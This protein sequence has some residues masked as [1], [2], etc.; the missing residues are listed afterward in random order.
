MS[1]PPAPLAGHNQPPPIDFE[2]V[3]R[4]DLLRLQLEAQ[5]GDLFTKRDQLLAAGARFE[6]AMAELGIQDDETL[7]KAA[8]FKKQLAAFSKKVEST[9]EEVKAPFNEAGKVVQAFFKASILDQIAGVVSKVTVQQTAYLRAKEARARAE[10]EAAARLAQQEA[11]KAAA[12]AR[13]QASLAAAERAIEAEQIAA[14]AAAAAQVKPADLARTTSDLG[15]TTSLRR[16]LAFKVVDKAKV[17]LHL[18]QVV[19]AAVLQQGRM[20]KD[21]VQE[22][23][24]PGVEFHWVTAAR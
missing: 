3:L 12:A 9:R 8:D 15:V 1:E 10:R 21:P 14:D 13:A 2:E 20:A 22:Q 7:G 6:A 24:V 4:P 11:E 17:P 16:T 23:P 18:M 19:D 5:H